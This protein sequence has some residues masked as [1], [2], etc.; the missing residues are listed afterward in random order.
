MSYK[1]LLQENF[2]DSIENVMMRI[3]ADGKITDMDNLNQ[4]VSEYAEVYAK[5]FEQ[6]KTAE[7]TEKKIQKLTVADY[8]RLSGADVDNNVLNNFKLL[9][10]YYTQ[11]IKENEEYYKEIASDKKSVYDVLAESYLLPICDNFKKRITGKDK[12]AINEEVEKL[13]KQLKQINSMSNDEL[14]NL[15]TEVSNN[16]NNPAIKKRLDEL[17]KPE[18][19]QK[20]K[21]AL[22]KKTDAIKHIADMKK[23][24]IARAPDESKFDPKMLD[25]IKK[26]THI[27]NEQLSK[28]D[29]AI[30]THK[31]RAVI[32]SLS[33]AGRM[34]VLLRMHGMMSEDPRQAVATVMFLFTTASGIIKQFTNALGTMPKIA[35]LKKQRM[36]ISEEKHKTIDSILKQQAENTGNPDSSL[37]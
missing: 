25:M 10:P 16:T 13:N 18:N 8:S 5:I 26:S 3:I 15:I 29:E 32:S 12:N 35:Q 27:I 20:F 37:G 4:R 11:V 19:L 33:G 17:L 6:E 9:A 30:K 2:R 14:K 1:T 31:S 28:I 23:E 24:R 21:I 22:N 36:K 34:L 7:N